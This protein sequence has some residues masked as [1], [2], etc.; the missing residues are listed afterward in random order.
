MVKSTKHNIALYIR[1]STEEQAENP[2]GSIRNQEER[3]KEMIRFK[4]ADAPFGEISGV[5]IDRA[6]SGKDTNRPELQRML[7]AIRRRE[8]TLVMVTELS[9][10]SRSIKDFSGIW[11]LMQACKCQFM[12]LRENFDTTTAAGEMVLYTVANIAQ[13]ERRQ[14]SER[15]TANFQSRA[16]R[17]LYNGGVLPVGYKLIADKPGFLDIDEEQAEIVKAAFSA[18]QKKR[19]LTQAAKWLNE[20]GYRVRQKTEGGGSRPRLGHFTVQNLSSILTNKSYLG[21]RTYKTKDG[22]KETKANWPAII[23]EL[24]FHHVQNI[25]SKSRKRK[26][27]SEKRYPFTL[28]GLISCGRCGERMVGKSAYGNSGKVPYYEHGW[29]TRKLGCIAKPCFD[30]SPFRVQA[31]K[32]EPAVWAKVEELL[33]NPIIAEKILNKAKAMHAKRTQTSET[34][35]IKEKINSLKAQSELLAERL[36][37]IPKSVSPEPIFKQ[38]EKIEEMKTKETARLRAIEQDSGPHEMPVSLS[39]YRA[40]IAGLQQLHAKENAH[41]AQERMI[42]ALIHGIKIVSDGY[43][44]EYL[45][46]RDYV[47]RELALASSPSQSFYGSNSLTSGGFDYTT[48]KSSL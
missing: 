35:R 43:E 15:V 34:K 36:A 12:S 16:S 17:G 28:T 2:E 22:L 3:L 31:K 40:F 1:V 9:R 45:V 11:E 33:C 8:I 23:N 44:I 37:L 25:L 47:E 39:N 24:T 32:L 46:G 7:A 14:I 29:S 48:I 6:R 27:E 20:N 38:M 41:I 5:F 18:I 19:T 26:P 13:F 30:C 42:H 10:L 21:I 4:N